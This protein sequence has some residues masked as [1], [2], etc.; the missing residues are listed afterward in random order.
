MGYPRVV[1]SSLAAAMS[2][3]MCA[4]AAAGT[5]EGAVAFPSELVPSMTIYA[6]E[7]ETSR[8]HTATL[9]RGQKSFTLDLPPG[10]YLVFVSP[11]EP[12]A[13]HIYGAFT[14]YSLCST[15]EAG[16]CED[17]SL[18]PVALAAKTARAAVTVDDWYL[19]DEVSTQIDHIRGLAGGDAQPFSAPRFSEYP[20]D[21]A[22]VAAAPKLDLSGSDLSDEEIELVTRALAGGPNFAG[23]LTASVTRCGPACNRLVLVDW[24]NGAVVRLPPEYAEPEIRGLPCRPDEAALFRRDSRLMS[25]SRMRG[26]TVVT[27][28]YVWNQKTAALVRSIEYQRTSQTFCSVAA[29]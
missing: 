5:L 2:L 4:G 9:A 12:G 10:R 13:P 11:N 16:D 17:H 25:L 29:R 19:S 27:Q 1:P 26:A 20:S 23:H 7:A 14:R 18:I 22:D 24:S 3:G 21:P 28:Y 6:A 8:I 15:Q